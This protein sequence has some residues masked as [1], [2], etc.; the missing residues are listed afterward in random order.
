MLWQG[1]L[2]AATTGEGKEIANNN[3]NNTTATRVPTILG[4]GCWSGILI[5]PTNLI[6]S[7]L[8]AQPISP[9]MLWYWPLMVNPLPQEKAK[10]QQTTTTTTTNNNKRQQTIH[11]TWHSML[12]WH[13][14]L[15]TT[16]KI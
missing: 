14:D 16:N 5:F 15:A 11:T 3:N 6:H 2:G 9:A 12:V 10:R 13:P 7:Y 8:D 1:P 4:A